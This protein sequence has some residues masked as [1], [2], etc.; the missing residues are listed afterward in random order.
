[1]K[2]SAPSN[3]KTPHRKRKKAKY[4]AIGTHTGAFTGPEH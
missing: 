4:S 2:A 3:P 1:V